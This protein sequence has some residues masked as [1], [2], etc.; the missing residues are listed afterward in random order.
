MRAHRR[1]ERGAVL[2]EFALSLVLLIT[3][4]F[5][6]V[7]FGLA[8]QDRL[9][10]QTATRAGVRVGSNLTTN[11]Q[12]DYNILQ[13]VKSAIN[14]VGLGNVDAV[15][16]YKSTTADGSVP[17]TCVSPSVHSVVATCNAYTGA[18]LASIVSSQFGCGVGALDL[19]WCPTVRQNLQSVGPD[20][21]GVWIR[22]THHNLTSLFGSSFK[23][24]DSAVMRL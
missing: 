10:L 11:S 6:I 15:V 20:Y 1:P 13:A 7:E 16:I 8:W 17:S 18:Q 12:A 21:L 5:G 9:T 19:S 4:L 23:M 24:T 2:V 22:V 3:L 14:D